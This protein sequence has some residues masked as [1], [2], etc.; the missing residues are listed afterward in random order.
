[1]VPSTAASYLPYSV[2]FFAVWTS[3]MLCGMVVT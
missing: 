3:Y 2:T 1:M